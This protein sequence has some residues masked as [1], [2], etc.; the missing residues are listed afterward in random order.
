MKTDANWP[1][2]ISMSA[3]KKA[4]GYS[5]SRYFAEST[6]LRRLV[7]NRPE[8]RSWQGK[9]LQ[10]HNY[11]LRGIG[12]SAPVSGED[13]WVQAT[14]RRQRRWHFNDL[15]HSLESPIEPIVKATSN[16]ARTLWRL[17]H[18][19][20]PRRV[21]SDERA[22]TYSLGSIDANALA[23]TLFARIS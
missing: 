2:S 23:S 22:R 14:S 5:V 6:V 8:S 15:T 12:L 20:L 3:I 16:L 21:R 9:Y 19:W 10:W 1:R 13:R 7:Q 17:S 18:F 4:L 11:L